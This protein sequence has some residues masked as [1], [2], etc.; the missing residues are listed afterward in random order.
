MQPHSDLT[1]LNRDDA[2][3]TVANTS[4]RARASSQDS[5]SVLPT[6]EPE[7]Q[8]G[9]TVLG[10]QRLCH[11]YNSTTQMKILRYPGSDQNYLERV[12]FPDQRLLFEAN[13]C[14]LLE[15][16]TCGLT[17]CIL[18]EQIKCDRI[19]VQERTLS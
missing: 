18:S 8:S 3:A 17:G 11:Y 9:V 5:Q 13:P 14:D 2:K 6:L 4:K 1:C 12:V 7:F 19:L 10:E 15:V 16:Y